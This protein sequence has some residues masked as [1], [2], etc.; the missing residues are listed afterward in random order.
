M[1]KDNEVAKKLID[2]DDTI[3]YKE[4]Y[5]GTWYEPPNAYGSLT[6]EVLEFLKGLP[7]NNLTLAYIHGLRPS[8]IRVSHGCICCDSMPNRVT[9]YLDDSDKIEKISQEINVGYGTGH[10][11]A[12]VYE[13]LKNNK[14]IPNFPETSPIYFDPSIFKDLEL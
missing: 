6:I 11:V 8:T 2:N 4:A 7:F 5:N 13:A 10:V 1:K 3:R 12:N 9:V 14:Q